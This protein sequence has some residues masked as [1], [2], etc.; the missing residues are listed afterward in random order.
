[1]QLISFG[2]NTIKLT[3]GCVIY[4][5]LEQDI[6]L[7]SIGMDGLV[8]EEIKIIQSCKKHTKEKVQQSSSDEYE[9]WG[10]DR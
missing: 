9:D 8:L 6:N 4:L 7:V 3:C 10:D 2:N 1:M 5:R